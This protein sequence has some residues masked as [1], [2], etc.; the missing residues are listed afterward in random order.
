MAYN[1][2]PTAE[3]SGRVREAGL[4]ES[5]NECFDT[6]V[7]LI[8]HGVQFAELPCGAISCLKEEK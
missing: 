5:V 2:W 6:S 4:V 7:S 3:C 8:S 1:N